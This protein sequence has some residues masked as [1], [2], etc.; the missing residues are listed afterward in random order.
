MPADHALIGF[1]SIAELFQEEKRTR[2]GRLLRSALARSKP[3]EV[4]WFRLLVGLVNQAGGDG[5]VLAEIV[6]GHL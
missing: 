4:L 3:V 1:V 2:A 6:V 5:E